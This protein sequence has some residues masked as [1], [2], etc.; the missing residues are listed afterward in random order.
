MR[1]V[2]MSNGVACC[3]VALCG[4]EDP[5]K[6]VVWFASGSFDCAQDDRFLISIAHSV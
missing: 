3:A 2:K 6:T 1:N 4:G 5:V